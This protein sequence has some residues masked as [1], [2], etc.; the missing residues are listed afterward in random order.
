[1]S[2]RLHLETEKYIVSTVQRETN[3]L[4]ISCTEQNFPLP[5]SSQIL[6]VDLFLDSDHLLSIGG[7]LRH[8]NIPLPEKHPLLIPGKHHILIALNM[9]KCVQ[10]HK[11]R[12]LLEL[13]MMSNLPPARLEPGPPFS[14]VGVYVFEHND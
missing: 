13:Q 12:R 9:H 2:L 7:R 1:M 6:S 5:K 10:C 3:T 11:L 4:E 8:A 14:N